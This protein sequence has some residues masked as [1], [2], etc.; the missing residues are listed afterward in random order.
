MFLIDTQQIE[1][2][3]AKSQNFLDACRY[4]SF[5]IGYPDRTANFLINNGVFSSFCGDSQIDDCACIQES[6]SIYA[7]ISQKILLLDMFAVFEPD[8]NYFSDND[9]AAERMFS[10]PFTLFF[11]T[12]GEIYTSN[13]SP[14]SDERCA[15]FNS[16]YEPL[17][18]SC[19]SYRLNVY[20]PKSPN[21]IAMVS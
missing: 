16:C 13:R 9:K 10:S 6:K 21:G 11:S 4:P 17:K 15:I 14:Y 12:N 1:K 3:S 5:R 20:I 18:F 2:L 8:E 19:C 7:A